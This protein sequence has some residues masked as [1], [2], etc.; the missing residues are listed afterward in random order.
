MTDA[1]IESIV[2]DMKATAIAKTDL[3]PGHAT[4]MG[5]VKTIE[6][7]KSGKTMIVTLATHRGTEFVDRISTVG[8]IYVFE[9]RACWQHEEFTPTC[10]YCISASYAVD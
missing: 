5:I 3:K 7:S 6:V 9:T 4:S 8:K 2:R 1:G 10:I